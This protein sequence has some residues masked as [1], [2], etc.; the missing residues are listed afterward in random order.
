MSHFQGWWFFLLIG[1]LKDLVLLFLFALTLLIYVL[2]ALGIRHASY[3]TRAFI[4][5][6]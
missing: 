4:T 5:R 1:D 6:T 2:K 3:Q